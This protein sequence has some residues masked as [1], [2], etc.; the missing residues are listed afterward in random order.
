MQRRSQPRPAI[1]ELQSMMLIF[2]RKSSLSEFARNVAE[3]IFL[4]RT[5]FGNVKIEIST[6]FRQD[7][8]QCKFFQL[9]SR[10]RATML[11]LWMIPIS[12]SNEPTLPHERLICT[13]MRK[14]IFRGLWMAGSDTYAELEAFHQLDL[15]CESSLKLFGQNFMDSTTCAAFREQVLPPPMCDSTAL[16]SYRSAVVQAS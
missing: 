7:S 12:Q 15:Y 9:R 11:F 2:N 8:F 16:C 10:L 3:Q 14:Q 4:F 6:R 13:R 1:S 5:H